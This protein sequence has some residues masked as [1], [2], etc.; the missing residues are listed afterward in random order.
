MTVATLFSEIRYQLS[1]E[2]KVSYPD[3]ELITYLN[4]V[5]EFVYSTVIDRDSN[6][7]LTKATVTLTDGVGAL[8]SDFVVESVV[9]VDD[10][11]DSVSPSVTPTSTQYNIMGD[12]I[13]SDNDSITL[14]Y[15]VMP[16][17]YTAT[18]DELTIPNYFQN[19]Y[20]QMIKFL[21]FETDEYDTGME[22]ALMNRFEGDILKLLGKRGNSKIKAPMPFRM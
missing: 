16:D 14:F 4:Q 5:N 7:T 12:S 1:D 10:R 20:R 11:L 22:Q 18:T 21:A 9:M 15:H 17:S 2:Q 8:P 3:P 13:Y 19:L 6:L